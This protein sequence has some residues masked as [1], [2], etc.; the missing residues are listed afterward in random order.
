MTVHCLYLPIY[1]YVFYENDTNEVNGSYHDDCLEKRKTKQNIFCILN[2]GI[3]VSCSKN[4]NFV[5]CR[6]SETSEENFF[7]V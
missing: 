6:V 4:M 3:A 1:N 7:N 2:R 5:K